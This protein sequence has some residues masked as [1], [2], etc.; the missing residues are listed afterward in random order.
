MS[1][2]PYSENQGDLFVLHRTLGIY[3]DITPTMDY[4]KERIM[5]NQMDTEITQKPDNNS[6]LHSGAVQPLVCEQM[7][8]LL[9]SPAM[10]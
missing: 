6:T 4:E 8:S 3:L 1:V 5:E 10:I 2:D 7:S 9:P